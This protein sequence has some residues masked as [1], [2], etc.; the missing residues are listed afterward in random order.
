MEHFQCEIFS[1]FSSY[2][3]V[4]NSLPITLE[5]TWFL[6]FILSSRM[7]QIY[8]PDILTEEVFLLP[9][10]LLLKYS[11]DIHE[12]EVLLLKRTVR[13]G[14]S[15]LEFMHDI[16][17]ETIR[18]H[19]SS[20]GDFLDWMD[21]IPLV[22]F[23]GWPTLPCNFLTRSMKEKHDQKYQLTLFCSLQAVRSRKPLPNKKEACNQGK[24]YYANWS[25]IKK[26]IYIPLIRHILL[27]LFYRCKIYLWLIQ[28]HIVLFRFRAV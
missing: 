27:F 10:Y 15:F 16:S 22:N 5:R 17:V 21:C 28:K 8:G 11:W 7:G 12:A 3:L 6:I 24:A 13:K 26:L 23:I 19:S 1:T 2:R 4:R 20:T 18:K 25:F 14:T 9:S